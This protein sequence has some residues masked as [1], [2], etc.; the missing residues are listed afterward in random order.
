LATAPG[1]GGPCLYQTRARCPGLE[2]SA[3][4]GHAPPP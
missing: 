1:R 3:G 2:S 4:S